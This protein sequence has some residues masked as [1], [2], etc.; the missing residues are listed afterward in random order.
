MAASRMCS[1]KIWVDLDMLYAIFKVVLCLF[2]GG[3]GGVSQPVVGGGGGRVTLMLL[4]FL[5][6]PDYLLV[7]GNFAN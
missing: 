7:W 3:G 6:T 1:G 4:V 2:S 5:R